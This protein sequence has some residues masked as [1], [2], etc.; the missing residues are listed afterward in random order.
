MD[1]LGFYPLFYVPHFGSA[2]LM[3]LTG[4]IHIMASHTSVGC[5]AF[6]RIFSL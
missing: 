2:W 4:A 1:L 5:G 6:V 3:G